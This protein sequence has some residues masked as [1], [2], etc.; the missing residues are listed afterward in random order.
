MEGQGFKVPR[1]T[2]LIQFEGEEFEGCEVRVRL[3][4][5]IGQQQHMETLK[6]DTAG[7][8]EEL[9]RFFSEVCIESWNLLSEDDQPIPPS[10]EAF[11]ALPGWFGLAIMTGWGRAVDKAVSVTDPLEAT[12]NDGKSLEEASVMTGASSSALPS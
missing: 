8:Q 10:V 9:L 6:D 2:A 7:N 4:V 1:K 3:D 5:T 12:S 11:M